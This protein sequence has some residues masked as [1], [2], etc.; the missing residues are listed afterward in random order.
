M[1]NPR[2]VENKVVRERIRGMRFGENIPEQSR[3]FR[4]Q[5]SCI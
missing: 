2:P 3:G 4:E 1:A 5:A